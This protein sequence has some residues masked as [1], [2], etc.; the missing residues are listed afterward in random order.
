MT[1]IETIRARRSCRTYDGHSL[2][3]GSIDELNAFLESNREGPFGGGVLFKL[4]ALD[5]L[6]AEAL[7][8][9]G[10]YGVI[11]EARYFLLGAVGLRPLAMEDFGY[12]MEKNILKA[13]A[14]GIGTCWLAGTFRRSGFARQMN[15]RKGEVLPAVSPLGHPGES[16]S[17]TE[18]FFRFSAGADKRKPWGELFFDGNLDTPLKEEEAGPFATPL[19]C[20]RLAPSASNK[21]PWRAVREVTAYHLYLSRT[22]GYE[23]FSPDILLQN[24]DMGI[25]LC[26]FE[27]A[28]RELG[29]NGTWRRDA[30]RIAMGDWE[31]IVTW[32][33]T[34]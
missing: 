15:L 18:R 2:D 19:E 33:T 4:L 34:H 1:I 30:S 13:T 26:H 11:K 5:D 27:L 6:A 8:T 29:L 3:Q 14:M 16:R 17:L 32:E 12:C 25:A 22:P 9:V 7:K 28:A 20:I 10:T 24:I 31:Y 23:K 21:Q